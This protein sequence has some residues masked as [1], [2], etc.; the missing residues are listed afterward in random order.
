MR[1]HHDRLN[2]LFNMAIRERVLNDDPCRLVSRTVLKALPSWEN[3]ERWLNKYSP[4][5]EERLFAT[6]NEY[7]E[8]LKAL[9]LIVLNTGARPPKEVMGIKKSTSISQTRRVLIRSGRQ[10]C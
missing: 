7:G 5:E 3:R 4:D 9:S 1:R 2:Q 10:T 6:F 8:H